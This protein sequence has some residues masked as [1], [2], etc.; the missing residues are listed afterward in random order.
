MEAM[1]TMCGSTSFLAHLIYRPSPSSDA[2]IFE[3]RIRFVG[4][5]PSP[6][7]FAVHRLQPIRNLARNYKND[8]LSLI[9][10]LVRSPFQDKYFI[11]H[12]LTSFDPRCCRLRSGSSL[13]NKQMISAPSVSK[14]ISFSTKHDHRD[15]EHAFINPRKLAPSPSQ[16]FHFHL[17]TSISFY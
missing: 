8:L 14:Y 6:S 2:S 5:F 12:S 16:R 10:P 17:R 4:S 3:K 9:G 15:S 7:M 13:N 11:L 1:Y